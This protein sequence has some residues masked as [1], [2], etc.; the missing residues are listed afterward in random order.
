M[1]FI[2]NNWFE[3]MVILFFCFL[4]YAVLIF[5][6]ELQTIRILLATNFDK[7][8]KD[9]E[10]SNNM[11]NEEQ[12]EE[13]L[14]AIGIMRRILGRLEIKFNAEDSEEMEELAWERRRIKRQNSK[15]D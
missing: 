7:I 1:E 9:K 10:I 6:Y 8:H 4:I 5:Y 2:T 13:A 12:L 3:I 11:V 14:G 15:T